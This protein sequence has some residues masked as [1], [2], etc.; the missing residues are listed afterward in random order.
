ML[1]EK[2]KWLQN[3]GFLKREAPF[4]SRRDLIEVGSELR[5]RAELTIEEES[6]PAFSAVSVQS[7]A[8]SLFHMLELLETQGAFTLKRFIERLDE[9]GGQRKSRLAITSDPRFSVLR[10]LVESGGCPDHPKVRELRG[11]VSGQVRSNPHSRVLVF[12]QYRDTATHLVEELNAAGGG[13]IRAERFVGQSSKLR[14]RGLTQDQQATLV[15]DLKKGYVNTLCCT[16]IAEEGLDIP[17]VDLVVFYE[18]IPSEIRYIQRRGRTGRNA[19]GRVIILATDGTA[20]AA[21]LQ[22]SQRRTE[23]MRSITASLNEKLVSAFRPRARPPPDPMD[24]AQV[25]ALGD[26]R[27]EAPLTT[28]R[29][30]EYEKSKSFNRMVERAS[31]DLYMRVLDEGGGGLYEERLCEEMEALGYARSAVVAGI[32]S[33]VK[34]RYVVSTASKEGTRISLA[35]KNIPDARLLTIEVKKLLQGRAIVILDGE[36][37]AVLEASNYV[38]PRELMK[39]GRRFRALCELYDTAEALNVNVRQVL[40]TEA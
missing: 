32:Q 25:A 22:A 16:S 18:P 1:N 37:E 8:L 15:E 24:G 31:Y 33:L 26:L 2:V 6:G 14:N 19:P 17:E 4:V 13:A 7:Q 34:R 38:G 27:P 20:D 21:Y 3:R 35:L 39:K 10:E 5:Y 28:V 30:E 12:T 9:E 11:I 36:R 40:Q 23:T 29:R